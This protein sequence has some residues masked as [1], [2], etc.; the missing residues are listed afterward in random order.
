M[1]VEQAR[2]RPATRTESAVTEHEDTPL[3]EAP[4]QVHRH[5]MGRVRTWMLDLGLLGAMTGLV[6]AFTSL[7]FQPSDPSGAGASVLYMTPVLL[8]AAAVLAG[9]VA[10]LSLRALRGRVP[11]L[12]GVFLAGTAVN[13][14]GSTVSQALPWELLA[15]A[16]VIE[17]KAAPLSISIYLLIPLVTV[18]RWR[19][20][21]P[22]P[23]LLLAGA[24]A[25][26]WIGVS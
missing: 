15:G 8:G 20:R 14:V 11:A 18:L 24:L 9:A 21:S 4:S 13:L 23:W 6:A 22:L 10:G 2:T 19:D 16:S 26:A 1:D 3:I 12:L 5:P 7:L 17:G 25:G